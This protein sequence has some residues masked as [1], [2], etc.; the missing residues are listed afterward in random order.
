M[1]MHKSTK[2]SQNMWALISTHIHLKIFSNNL[3]Q[4]D[5]QKYALIFPFPVLENALYLAPLGK[6]AADHMH[7]H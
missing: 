4:T 1:H 3:D 7:A 2:K 5:L 6:M